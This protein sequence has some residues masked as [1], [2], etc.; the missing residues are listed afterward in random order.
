MKKEKQRGGVGH[1]L[2]LALILMKQARI[3][4]EMGKF[5]SYAHLL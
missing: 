4:M 3:N 2:S 5:W 1:V